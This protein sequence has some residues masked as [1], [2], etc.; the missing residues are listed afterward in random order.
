MIALLGA[1]ELVR[2]RTIAWRMVAGWAAVVAPWTFFAFTCFGT[3]VPQSVRIKAV[4]SRVGGWAAADPF[5]ERF[6]LQSNAPLVTWA[7]CMLGLVTV[8]RRMRGGDFY[9]FL[10]VAFGVTQVAAYSLGDAPSEYR[11]YF[12]AGNLAV[13]T[14]VVLALLAIAGRLWPGLLGER[15]SG[16]PRVLVAGLMVLVVY[17]VAATRGRG[18]VE[19]RLA[20]DYRE[21]AEWIAANTP[22]ASRVACTE[23]GYL[24]YFSAREI[25]DV[26][27]LI[28]PDATAA[29][30]AGELSWWFR[31]P[32]PEVV[33]VHDPPWY[34]E[35]G[36]T[37]WPS[38]LGE[39]ATN[40][41]R[42]VHNVGGVR[43]LLRLP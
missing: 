11:W 6:V 28:H 9:L 10:V 1:T 5:F 36:H 27:A 40:A 22:A 19:Y 17:Q 20:S 16:R 3:L 23:I 26:H 30:Q 25:V 38:E 12:A 31:D 39:L 7:L 13:D 4:Q 8:W 41:Y 33:V 43:I 42:A 18:I 29:I 32:L 2:R 34:G 21:A 35:P 24:G 14:C 15:G 37:S